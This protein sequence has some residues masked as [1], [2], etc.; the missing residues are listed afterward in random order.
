MSDWT[1]D[2]INDPDGEYAENAKWDD[3]NDD[4]YDYDT[5]DVYIPDISTQSNLPEHLRGAYKL[6]TNLELAG[7][8]VTMDV[9]T[10]EKEIAVKMSI[11]GDPAALEALTNKLRTMDLSQLPGVKVTWEGENQ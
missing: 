9:S 6:K 10:S 2:S 8:I 5:D 1:D 4:D 7:Y 11:N 3:E